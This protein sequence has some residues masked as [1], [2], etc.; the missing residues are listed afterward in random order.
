MLISATA[1]TALGGDNPL[2]RMTK[3][4][5]QFAG[6]VVVESGAYGDL[7]ND[8]RTLAARAIRAFA[9]FSALGFVLRVVAEMDERIVAL[10]RLHDDVAAAAAVAAGGSPSGHEFFA[11]KGHASVAAV[12]GFYF[13]LCFIDKHFFL[14]I[15]RGLAP[16][17]RALREFSHFR[18]VFSVANG[19]FFPQFPKGS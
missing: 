8:V 17:A 11:A 9:V 16:L 7:Q 12:A 15:S 4:V 18:A 3:I 6:L 1:A 14:V 19:V 5:H 10:A 13:D 2:V